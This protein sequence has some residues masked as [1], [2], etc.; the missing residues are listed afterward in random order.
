MAGTGLAVALLMPSAKA[1]PGAR[2]G[3][4]RRRR[5]LRQGSCWGPCCHPRQGSCRG[6]CG[7]PLL[8]FRGGSPSSSPHLNSYMYGLDKDLHARGASRALV[9]TQLLGSEPVGSRVARSAGV[10]QVAPARLL[11]GLRGA[12]SARILPRESTSPSFPPALLVL[13]SPWLSCAS[14]SL[15]L[16]SSA[17]LSVAAARGS[18]CPCTSKG[19]KRRAPTFVHRQEP[20]G[21]GHT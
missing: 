20:P 13:A 19:V 17:L 9:P 10:G 15:W 14:A 5:H 16:P 1:L 11:P 21:L 4:C 8:G 12:A 2:Q 3:S 7:F 6:P 18:D